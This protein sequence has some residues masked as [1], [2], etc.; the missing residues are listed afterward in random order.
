MSRISKETIL[1]LIDD[2]VAPVNEKVDGNIDSV[3]EKLSVLEAKVLEIKS[4]N[5]LL[6]E[7]VNQ[8]KTENASLN[9][10]VDHLKNDISFVKLYIEH[11][12]RVTDDTNQYSKK[13]NIIIE[14]LKISK[15]DSNDKIRELLLKEIRRLDLDIE[16]YEID[17][18]FTESN[19]PTMTTTVNL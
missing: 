8:L 6:K 10:S 3:N 12:R 11:L 9:K 14:G 1:Q 18:V 4:E 7:S 5:T 19:H 17:T 2:V 15:S 13:Q 16:E